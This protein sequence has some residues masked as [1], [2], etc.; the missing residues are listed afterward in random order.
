MFE[1]YTA[2]GPANLGKSCSCS[3]G[4]NIHISLVS[5]GIYVSFRLLYI[6]NKPA[7]NLDVLLYASNI[8]TPF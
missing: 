6:T 7:G 1:L 5:K 4:P 8:E 2:K 3:I